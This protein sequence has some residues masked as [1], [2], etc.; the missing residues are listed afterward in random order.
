MKDKNYKYSAVVGFRFQ[1]YYTGG[2]DDICVDGVDAEVELLV[3]HYEESFLE[4]EFVPDKEDF[5]L[6]GYEK[7]YKDLLNCTSTQEMT[8]IYDKVHYQLSRFHEGAIF[9]LEYAYEVYLKNASEKIKNVRGKGFYVKVAKINR[10]PGTTHDSVALTCCKA[11]WKS[12][13][14][15]PKN[16]VYFY[17]YQR[18]FVFPDT[19]KEVPFG[20]HT[21]KDFIR[22]GTEEHHMPLVKRV[23]AEEKEK[24]Y[25]RI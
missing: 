8:K 1:D 9:G 5:I 19:D 24:Y 2:P 7:E 22:M 10:S 16:M 17:P 11:F 23:L 14:F 15:V 12:V 4:I 3:D 21:L 13:S 20:P 6:R 18:R 25:N